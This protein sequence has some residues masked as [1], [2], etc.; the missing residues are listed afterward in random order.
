MPQD[1][2][3]VARS[4]AVLSREGADQSSVRFPNSQSKTPPTLLL[5]ALSIWL[6]DLVPSK[7]PT[8]NPLTH[9]CVTGASTSFLALS[10]DVSLG[11]SILRSHDWAQ[12]T[13][14]PTAPYSLIR[15]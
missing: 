14:V 12:P 1:L 7:G 5:E 2:R 13:V 6:P 8:S 11:G 15:P 3:Q 10:S 4:L 9:E